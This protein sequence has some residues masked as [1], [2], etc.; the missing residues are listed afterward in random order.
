MSQPSWTDRKEVDAGGR[1][2]AGQ[3][4]ELALDREIGVQHP[5]AG[6][7]AGT[8]YH[9]GK[10]VV[11]LR[12]EDH[13]HEGRA[14]HDLLALRLGDAARDGDDHAAAVFLGGLTD[15]FNAQAAKLGKD[16]L[17]RLLA[18]MAGVQDDH[19]GPVGG[20]DRL[21]AQRR[22]DIGHTGAVIDIHLAAP[23]LDE[24]FLLGQM[25]NPDARSI[26]VTR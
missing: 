12:A 2:L 19:I 13:V 21:I 3:E 9:F 17:R 7:A 5:L 22:Q 11:G 18:D 23:G 14:G 15:F 4:V 25:L 20:L 24:Q 10:L 26:R 8:G 16:L 1:T 6:G